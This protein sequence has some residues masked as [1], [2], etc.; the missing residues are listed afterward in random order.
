M[1]RVTLYVYKCCYGLF[2]P[3]F[4][5]FTLLF[6]LSITLLISVCFYTS[7][8]L[9]FFFP[10]FGFFFIVIFLL[11][12]QILVRTMVRNGKETQKKGHHC[13]K[14]SEVSQ[15][16]S[17]PAERASKQA[18]KRVS[19]ASERRKEPAIRPVLQYLFL[20]ILDHSGKVF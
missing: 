1:I 6:F 2:N 9:Q 7:V 13:P 4:S 15:R 5:L 19:G 17:E 10:Y 12:F 8:L 20:I 18:S 14:S 3:P 11:P 16:A